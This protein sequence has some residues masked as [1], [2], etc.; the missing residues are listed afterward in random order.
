MLLFHLFVVLG[1]RYY[2]KKKNMDKIPEYKTEL[3]KLTL[4]VAT[5]VYRIPRSARYIRAI[6]EY[7]KESNFDP[8][9]EGNNL[10]TEVVALFQILTNPQVATEV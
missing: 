7:V 9:I 5:R 4:N 8:A 2:L 10:S 6:L 1:C 3:R